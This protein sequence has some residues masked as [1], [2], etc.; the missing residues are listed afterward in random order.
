MRDELLNVTQ[1]PKQPFA[2]ND[3][4]KLFYAKNTKAILIARLALS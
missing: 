4:K 1:N 2:H 3:L